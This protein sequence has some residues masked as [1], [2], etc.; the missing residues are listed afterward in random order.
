MGQSK[1]EVYIDVLKVLAFRGPLRASDVALQ[2]NADMGK[3]QR[4]LEFLFKQGLVE[5]SRAGGRRQA[6]SISPQG[7]VVLRYFK[8]VRSASGAFEETCKV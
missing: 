7:I 1:F 5:E 2:H 6:Y 4:A 8:E 3:A